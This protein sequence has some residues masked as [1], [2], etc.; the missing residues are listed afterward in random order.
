MEDK[1]FYINLINNMLN[2]LSEEQLIRLYTMMKLA[3]N[4]KD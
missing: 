3:L 4:Q 2:L 1:E